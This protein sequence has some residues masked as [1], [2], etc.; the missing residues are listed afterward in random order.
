VPVAVYSAARLQKNRKPHGV[1]LHSAAAAAVADWLRAKPAGRPVWDGH[2][3]WRER[4]ADLVR[5]DLAAAGI[6]F[7]DAAG[8]VFDFHAFRLQFGF[9]C[10]KYG[11]PLVVAQQLLDHSTPA[12]TANVYSQFGGE[13]GAEVEKLP[14][15]LGGG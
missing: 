11:V 7:Q 4:A 2:A 14:D 5:H 1:R 6:P 15:V 3:W 13:L 9:L 12:L 10:A 8:Q